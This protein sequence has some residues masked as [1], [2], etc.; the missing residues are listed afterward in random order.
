MNALLAL[1]HWAILALGGAGLSV[2]LAILHVA[3][4]ELRY[5]MQMHDF[6]IRVITLRNE[7]VR[8]LEA[9][10]SGNDP[11]GE[12]GE[13]FDTPQPAAAPPRPIPNQPPQPQPS[14]AA[15]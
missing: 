4:S 1:P 9:L 6:K 7:Q 2:A 8:R 12:A 11:D 3:A 10:Y 13:I 14:R 5:H 15:A